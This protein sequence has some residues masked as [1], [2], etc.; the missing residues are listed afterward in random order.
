[1]N[2]FVCITRRR[3][4]AGSLFACLLLVAAC[5]RADDRPAGPGTEPDA[6]TVDEQSPLGRI[7][8]RVS[9]SESVRPDFDRALGLMHHMMYAQAREAFDTLVEKA[10]D[11]A[12]AYWGKATTLFQP[13]WGTRPSG[14]E[15]ATGWQLV[16]QARDRAPDSAR[17][18]ALI[19]ATAAFFREPETADHATRIKR[20][21]GAMEDAYRSHGDDHD[22]AALYAL[23]R[24]ALAQAAEDPHPLLDEAESILQKIHEQ[25]ETH[26]GAIHYAIHATDADGR[27]RNALHMVE[28]YGE[29][30]PDVPHALHMPTHIYVRLGDWPMVIDWN[31]RSAKAALA[32]PAGKHVSHHYAHAQDYLVYAHLQRGDD[33]AAREVLEEA[34]QRQDELQPTVISAFHSAA[35]PARFA[36]ERRDWERAAGLEPRTPGHLPWDGLVSR[37]AESHTR[38]ARGL[39]TAHT[40]DLEAARKE[41]ARIRELREKAAG[42]GATAFP[43]Y[44]RIDEHILAGRIAMNRGETEPAVEH[45]RSAAALEQR[46]EKH[47]VTPG[48]LMPPNEALGDLLMELGRPA[49]ALDAYRASDAIW[50]GRYNTL[51]GIARAAHAAGDEQL[52]GKA[53][54]QL[55]ANVDE[56]ER[57]GV[58]EAARFLE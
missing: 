18:R 10:P 39:G 37:W 51:L 33:A 9:C 23:S 34:G 30:A 32:H 2:D 5:D 38:L 8:F 54:G 36:V 46:L 16:G 47:P 13:L 24:V 52:A 43:D 45:L 58:R 29:I 48:A 19:E 53:Y 25:N 49:E 3:T 7:D 1:M 26:P 22:V 42:K 31:R 40:G 28:A 4:F 17:E 35:M 14:E 56:S 27:A 12:M 44:I 55:L 41:L 57:P 20:W 50:P 6:G 21:A 11:C 15:L